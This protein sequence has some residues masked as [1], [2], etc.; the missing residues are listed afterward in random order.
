MFVV[1]RFIL[2]FGLS[3]ATTSAPSLVS[4]LS[5]PKDRVTVTAICNTCWFVGSIAAAW[6]TYGTRRIPSTWSWRIPSLLQMVPSILQ[7]ATIWFLPE[8]PRWLISKDRDD[9]AMDALKQYHG[10]GEATELVRLEF[11]E[12]RNAIDNEKSR[13]SS[14]PS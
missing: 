1:S 3:F 7:L 12:I 11:E 2:G 8:S 10:E 5:H 4:E 6:I 9:A 14:P 13:P